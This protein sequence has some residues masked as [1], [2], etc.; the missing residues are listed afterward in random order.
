M[1]YIYWGFW[2]THPSKGDHVNCFSFVCHIGF[3]LFKCMFVFLYCCSSPFL[4]KFCEYLTNFLWYFEI[5]WVCPYL[6]KNELF[7]HQLLLRTEIAKMGLFLLPFDW[8]MFQDLNIY[9]NS[10]YFW[11]F[12]GSESEFNLTNFIYLYL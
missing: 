9:L 8:M 4:C 12:S 3:M 6:C 5:C 2:S 10:G 11:S 1:L 7:L